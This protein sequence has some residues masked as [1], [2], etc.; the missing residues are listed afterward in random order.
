MCRDTYTANATD[1]ARLRAATRYNQ[2]GKRGA[3][4]RDRD[5][6]RKLCPGITIIVSRERKLRP[7]DEVEPSRVR[8]SAK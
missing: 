7:K 3:A 6:L 4:S 1:E 8:R 5:L 2:Y